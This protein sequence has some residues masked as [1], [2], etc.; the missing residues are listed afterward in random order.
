[1]NSDPSFATSTPA[2]LASHRPARARAER[3]V[4]HLV[5]CVVATLTALVTKPAAAIVFAPMCSAQGE[6]IAAPA[7]G[8]AA[9]E[10]LLAPNG[11]EEKRDS[12]F[13]NRQPKPAPLPVTALEWIPRM[14]PIRYRLPPP[15][16]VLTP[17]E[18]TPLGERVGFARGIE[19][20]PR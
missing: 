14:P 16:R 9:K 19:R 18:S 12:R 5:F 4:R 7:I 17:V 20:P 8:R 13:E 6:T 11:C 1:M 2:T 15:P 3:L 10:A